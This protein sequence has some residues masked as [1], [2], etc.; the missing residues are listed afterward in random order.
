MQ[1]YRSLSSKHITLPVDAPCRAAAAAAE[2]NFVTDVLYDFIT[3]HHTYTRKIL[4][5]AICVVIK[6]CSC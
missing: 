3:H 5:I 4:L 1:R 2:R 6:E